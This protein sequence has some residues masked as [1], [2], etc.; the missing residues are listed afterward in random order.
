MQPSDSFE[1]SEVTLVR[2]YHSFAAALFGAAQ[3]TTTIRASSDP[4]GIVLRGMGTGSSGERREEVKSSP[5]LRFSAP[6]RTESTHRC[7]P[8][9]DGVALSL[10]FAR[11]AFAADCSS[12]E[13]CITPCKD[14]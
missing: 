1:R 8:A 4:S 14:Y 5:A 6:R 3:C 7:A 13:V 2:E 10:A 9:C 11:G 12:T